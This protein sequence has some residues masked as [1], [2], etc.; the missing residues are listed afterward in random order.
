MGQDTLQEALIAASGRLNDPQRQTKIVRNVAWLNLGLYIVYILKLAD[1]AVLLLHWPNEPVENPYTW[2]SDITLFS[3]APYDIVGLVASFAHLSLLIALLIWLSRIVNNLDQL[4][5]RHPAYSPDAAVINMLIPIWNLFHVHRLAQFVWRTNTGLSHWRNLQ[6]NRVIDY[7][8]SAF[9]ALSLSGLPVAWLM[10]QAGT[11]NRLSI[12][13][14][15]MTTQ[16]LLLALFFTWW[17]PRLVSR[18]T[19]AHEHTIVEMYR[20]SQTARFVHNNTMQAGAAGSGGT[21]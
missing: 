16:Q 1:K 14:F 3:V 4:G 6:R 7:W 11:T 12:A 13:I 19:Q 21:Q 5:I 18:I 10:M 8:S 9:V 20:Q 2:L 15:C 17:T